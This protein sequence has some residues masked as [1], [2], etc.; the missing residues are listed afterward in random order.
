MGIFVITWYNLNL[1]NVSMLHFNVGVVVTSPLAPCNNL[2]K[3]R[4]CCEDS[5]G[6]VIMGEYFVET[7]GK[8]SG[9]Y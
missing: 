4:P 9:K 1:R 8:D 6:D 2:S 3:A 7:L 5:Q